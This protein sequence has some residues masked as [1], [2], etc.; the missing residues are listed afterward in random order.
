MGARPSTAAQIRSAKI[1]AGRL[2]VED[3]HRA[4]HVERDMPDVL[5]ALLSPTEAEERLMVWLQTTFADQPSTKSELRVQW[6]G[7]VA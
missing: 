4:L 1:L 7:A 6:R 5:L 3:G 2:M